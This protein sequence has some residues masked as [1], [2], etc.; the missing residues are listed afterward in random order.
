MQTSLDPAVVKSDKLV[1]SVVGYSGKLP[2]VW[3][4]LKLKVNLLERV[5]GAKDKLVVE[6]IKLGEMLM[7]NVYS[8]ATVG[9]VRELGKNEVTC[10]LKKPVVADKTARVTIS[11]MLGQRWRLIGWGNIS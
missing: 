3:Y 7:L 5:V 1:G 6:P 9:T 10:I 8:S 2:P 4:E 11:R